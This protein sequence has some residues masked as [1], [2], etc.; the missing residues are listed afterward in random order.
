MCNA[1]VCV[2]AFF[3]KV[4]RNEGYVVFVAVLKEPDRHV[5]VPYKNVAAHTDSLF[6]SKLCDIV[7]EGVVHG[8]HAVFCL[9]ACALVEKGIGLELVA[10]GD[11][12]E[13][14]FYHV[15]IGFFIQLL[16]IDYSSHLKAML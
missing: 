15:C 11:A 6:L 5:S 12:V 13:V 9:L 8:R 1:V 10:G 3:H 4:R 16:R 2:K 7:C 14:C